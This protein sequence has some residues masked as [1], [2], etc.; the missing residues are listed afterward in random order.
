MFALFETGWGLLA[1]GSGQPCPPSS[2]PL[3]VVT[4]HVGP[5]LAHVPEGELPPEDVVVSVEGRLPLWQRLAYLA[6]GLALFVTALGLMRRGAGAL[7]P[8]L[9]GSIFTDNAWS[10]LGLGWLGACLVLSGSPVAASSLSL[11]DGGA[12]DRTQ[13]FT[14]LTGS[15]LG[16]AFVVLVVGVVYAVRG[17]GQGGRRAPISIG[18]L[19][20]L[21]TAIAYVPGAAVGYWLLRRGSFDGLTIG[22]SPSVTSLTDTLFGWAPDALEA[23]LPGW[24]LFPAGVL[25]LLLGFRLFDNVLPSVGSSELAGRDAAW[26]TRKWPMFL[27]GLVVTLAT[28]SVSVSLTLL[29]PLV[30]R[31]VLRRS[32]TLPYI[33]GANITT[34]IDTLVAAVLLGNQDGVRV[35]V[36]VT[37]CVSVWT[38]LLLALAYRPLRGGCLRIA[39]WV[40]ASR[41]RLAGFACVLFGV[42]LVLIAV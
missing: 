4:D 16:A 14:M 34:L 20:L 41:R 25:V 6:A 8:A 38:L 12:I 30:A 29:V 15:R 5:E 39:R 26:Y 3:T 2:L 23:V 13:S 9:S 31:G 21:M 36:A 24:T 18:I 37:V 19:S 22:T 27:L 35:V 40:L 1:P 28:L 10:T 17:R 32:N 11:L 7:I 42:P 33:A